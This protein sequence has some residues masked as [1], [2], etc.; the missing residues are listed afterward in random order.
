M[1]PARMSACSR[2]RNTAANTARLTC[3][4]RWTLYSF[5]MIKRPM[6]E[7]VDTRLRRY[8]RLTPAGARMLADEAKRLQANVDLAV[9]RLKLA[10]GAA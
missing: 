1:G 7:V 5:H 3:L 9:C 6:Q 8:Y 4:C 2:D 10:G